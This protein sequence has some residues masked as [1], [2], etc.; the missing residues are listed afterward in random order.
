MLKF[1]PVG[2]GMAGENDFVISYGGGVFDN[3]NC[4]SLLRRRSAP[5]HVVCDG[6]VVRVAGNRPEMKINHAVVLVGYGTDPAAGD[7]W[8]I[9]NSWGEQVTTTT[10]RLAV[11]CALHSCAVLCVVCCAVLCS[12]AKR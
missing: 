10:P 12:G 11:S 4:T 6:C 7:Y 9:R 3:M 2:V 8:I 1:G 5:R